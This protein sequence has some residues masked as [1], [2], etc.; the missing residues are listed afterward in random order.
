MQIAL[1]NIRAKYGGSDSIEVVQTGYAVQPTSIQRSALASGGLGATFSSKH[2]G[3]GSVGS[4]L[5]LLGWTI[6]VGLNLSSQVIPIVKLAS[7]LPSSV[8]SSSRKGHDA[9]SR[10]NT[11]PIHACS[12]ENKLKSHNFKKNPQK[13]KL[14]N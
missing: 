10:F 2:E 11:S 1:W 5:L 4:S 12:C 3:L 8:E 9:S 6:P 13:T 7:A 14:K